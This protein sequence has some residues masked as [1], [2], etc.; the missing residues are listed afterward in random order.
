MNKIVTVVQARMTSSRLPGKV[1]KVLANSP[2]LEHQINRIKRAKLIGALIVACST[3]DSDDGIEALCKENGVILYRGSLDDVLDRVYRASAT[4][5]PDHVVRLTGD[6]PLI[7]WTVIDRV[8][9]VH[10]AQNN[11]YTSNTLAATYPDGL[12]V[13]VIKFSCLKKAHLNARLKSE[14]EHVTPFLKN[15]TNRFKLGNVT[16]STDLS[17]LRWTV[18]ESLDFK[19]VQMI[20]KHLYP[21][22]PDFCLNDVVKL[23]NEH[24]ELKAINSHFIRDSGYAKSLSDD[25]DLADV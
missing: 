17:H 4:H 8:I 15:R 6:C 7:D 3:D 9:E 12:D 13:E 22:K 11:D 18:D 19:F 23:L 10:L 5:G 25:Q 24:P 21:T 14:R 1:L 2:M 16:N 20:Y